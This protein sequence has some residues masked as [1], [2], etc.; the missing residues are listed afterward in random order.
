MMRFPLRLTVDLA[1]ARLARTSR[2][3][4]KSAS[5]LLLAPMEPASP[6]RLD[7]CAHHPM[8]P[9]TGT[10]LL[11]RVRNAP[12]P[13]VWIGGSEPLLHP[14]MGQLTRCIAAIGRDVFLETDGALLRRRIHRI[15]PAPPVVLT[16]QLERNSGCGAGGE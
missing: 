9:K 15:R 4:A 7:S 3:N 13:V 5:V 11:A 14:E 16:I 1:L 2:E 8:A 10:E 12:A 6:S